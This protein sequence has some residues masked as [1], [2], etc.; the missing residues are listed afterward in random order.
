MKF[1][2][3]SFSI[4]TALLGTFIFNQ[5]YSQNVKK[6]YTV[7]FYSGLAAQ[8]DAGNSLER[9]LQVQS[10]DRDPDKKAA[11]SP[12]E[13]ILIKPKNKKKK[14]AISTIPIP[15]APKTKNKTETNK[16]ADVPSAIPNALNS[17]GVGVALS[18]DGWKEEGR[19]GGG[20]G[21]KT[22]NFPYQWYVQAVKK[23]LNE[24]WNVTEGASPRIYAQAAFTIIRDGSLTDIEIEEK[25]GNPVFDY[26]VQRTVDISGP[27]P[28]LPNDFKEPTLRVHVRFTIKK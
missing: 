10:D 23:K 5:I 21:G 14:E 13:N 8:N 19:I 15:K 22:G 3:Y 11:A 20:G 18:A 16:I 27:F 7:D 4:H 26:Q 9:S 1:V 17:S 25:S 24:N 6:Y 28:P 12:K 2:L